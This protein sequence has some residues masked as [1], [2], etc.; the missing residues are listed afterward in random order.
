MMEDKKVEAGTLMGI[1]KLRKE[2]AAINEAHKACA[3][4]LAA[5][6]WV[7]GCLPSCEDGGGRLP[8]PCAY[9]FH[10]RPEEEVLALA[11]DAVTLEDA[12]L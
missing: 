11:R 9:L 8:I 7:L 10:F 12:L 6:P 3:A 5:K 1:G 2:L 4:R